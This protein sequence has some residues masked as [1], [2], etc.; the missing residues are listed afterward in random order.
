M[1]YEYSVTYWND[2]EE[3]DMKERGLV[4]A[5]SYSEAADKVYQDFKK[6]LIDM[7]LQEWDSYNSISLDEIKRGFHL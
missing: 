3:K 5:N 6:D 4:W 2:Y 1:F 7:Y